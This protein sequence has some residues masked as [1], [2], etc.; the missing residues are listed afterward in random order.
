MK[1]YVTAMQNKET[2]QLF[3]SLVNLKQHPYPYLK[4]SFQN[5]T[6]KQ[7]K[8]QLLCSWEY[9]LHLRSFIYISVINTSRVVKSQKQTEM[10]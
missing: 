6:S 1:Q 5:W 8:L 10:Q 3:F 2:E 4:S 9:V 7:N